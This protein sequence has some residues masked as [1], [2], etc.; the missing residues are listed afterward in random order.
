MPLDLTSQAQHALK[1]VN[2]SLRVINQPYAALTA[3]DK[4]RSQ[5]WMIRVEQ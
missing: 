1:A 4:I 3:L 5:I 2:T